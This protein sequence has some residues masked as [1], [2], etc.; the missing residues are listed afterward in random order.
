[1]NFAYLQE[2][3]FVSPHPVIKKGK[4]SPSINPVPSTSSG[5]QG[6]PQ[7]KDNKKYPAPPVQSQIMGS[8]ELQKEIEEST[9]ALMFDDFEENIKSNNVHNSTFRPRQDGSDKN[10]VLLAGTF[11]Y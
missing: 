6:L 8:S 7:K 4:P 9:Q 2:V 11:F 3:H 10:I 5:S 1:M